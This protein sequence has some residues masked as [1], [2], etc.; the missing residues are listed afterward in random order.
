MTAQDDPGTIVKTSGCLKHGQNGTPSAAE[1]QPHCQSTGSWAAL[2]PRP[3]TGHNQAKCLIAV[4][5]PPGRTA[6]AEFAA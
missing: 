2:S 5:V 6:T 1:A 3:P 4:K